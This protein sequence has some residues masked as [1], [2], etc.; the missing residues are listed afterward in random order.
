MRIA[1][2]NDMSMAVNVLRQLIEAS[3]HQVAWV[4]MSGADAV[5]QCES[6]LP[7][8]ILM[9]MI[10]PD[11]N[12]V[13]TT[14]R[15]MASTPCPILVVTVSVSEN[16]S[17]VFEAMGAGALDAVSTPIVGADGMASG[18]DEF[19][20]KLRRIEKLLNL[21]TP[22]TSPSAETT[23]PVTPT[24]LA[25]GSSTGGPKAVAE[26]I[27]GLPLDFPAA[28]VIVQHVDMAFA[29]GFAEWLD[30]QIPLEVK[31]VM[32]GDRLEHGNVYVAST[33]NHLICGVSGRLKYTEGYQDIVYRPSVDVFFN[34]LSENWKGNVLAVLLTGMGR[35][36]AQGLLRL[37]E[38]GVYTIAQDE[39]SCA[40]YGMPRAAAE[41]GA[42][43]IVLP[44]DKI[45]QAIINQIKNLKQG[46][47]V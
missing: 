15:I 44:L 11:M 9:D 13:E 42:A 39:A 4:A 45:S 23:V 33:N 12:G 25:I 31:V 20:V 40:V 29:R 7:D 43:E 3:G 32:D 46:R 47:V 28:I 14:R 26:I 6:D 27:K 21:A 2:V 35:D 19:L 22:S 41:I 18:K 8:L 5:S 16:A 37:R 38:K 24:L 17:M 10:M 34:S 36:G 30:T 1:V